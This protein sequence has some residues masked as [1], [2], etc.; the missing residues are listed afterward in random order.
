MRPRR[1]FLKFVNKL[2]NLLIEGSVFDVFNM[3]FMKNM[4]CIGKYIPLH[5]QE[6]IICKPGS[7]GGLVL[8][9]TK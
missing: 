1:I 8:V 9:R 6:S 5:S 3:D 4:L 2:F 7:N